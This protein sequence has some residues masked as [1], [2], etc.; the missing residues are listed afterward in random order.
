MTFSNR[1]INTASL[2]GYL[3]LQDDLKLLQQT[4]PFLHMET[5]GQSVMGKEIPVI[6]I[7]CGPKVIHYNGAVH[8]NEWM[9]TSILMKFV[10]DYAKAYDEDGHL[11]E[12]K[13][14]DL[15]N[16]TSLWLVPMVNPDGVELVQENLTPL[17]PL[18]EQLLEWNEGSYDFQNWKANI[19][20]VDLNDQFPAHWEEERD[21]RTKSGPGPRDYGGEAPLTEPEAI[22]LAAFTHQHDFKLVMSF[23]SQGEEIYWNYRDLEPQES[24]QMAS[25]LAAASGYEAIKLIGSDAGYKDWF[26]QQFGKPGFTIEVGLGTNPLPIQ[27]FAD[28]YEDIVGLMIMGLTL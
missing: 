26:I 27:Q 20:G 13:A 14:A 8:A 25:K 21:R 19:R 22:A 7:G 28:I 24:F 16:Q 9:T 17:H 12:H 11:Q 23:H 2:Y 3:E 15:F 4:Y 1:I 5:M 10:E 6:R 18:Y